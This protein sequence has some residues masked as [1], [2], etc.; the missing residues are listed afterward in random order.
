M[1]EKL[2]KIKGFQHSSNEGCEKIDKE[3]TLETVEVSFI[4][5]N[6]TF[7]LTRNIDIL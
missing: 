2:N 1:K 6:E 5:F 4:L 7:S 3:T